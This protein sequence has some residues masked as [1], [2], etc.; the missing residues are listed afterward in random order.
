MVNTAKTV[1]KTRGLLAL[2]VLSFVIP[3]L[4]NAQSDT[5]ARVRGFLSI[6]THRWYILVATVVVIAQGALIAALLTAR[7]RRRATEARSNAILRAIPDLMFLQTRSGVYLD[8][9]TRDP[10]ILLVP[11]EQF[12]G[13]NMRDV[14]PPPLVEMFTERIAQLFNGQEPV[15]AEY[16]I[17]LP[18][19]E[20]GHFEARLVRCEHDK[21]LSI[22]RDVT[23]RSRHEKAIHEEQRRR[24]LANAAGAVGVWDWNLVTGDFYVDAELKALLGY[25][26]K[27]I[28]NHV[29][30]W[31]RLAHPDD[32]ERG[33]DIQSLIQAT[34]GEL[35]QRMIHKD[36][37]MR[38]FLVRGNVTRDERGVPIRLIG[39]SSDITDR[40]RAAQALDQAQA[41]LLR[42]SKLATLG[43]FAGSIT[44]ELAQPLTAI[45]ANSEACLRLLANPNVDPSTL[46][47]SLNDVL[48]SGELARDVISHTRHLF[49]KGD[50]ERS[51]VSLN[52]ILK[53]VS[54]LLSPTLLAK[55][56]VMTIQ[57]APDLPRIRGDRVQLRQVV[58]NLMN[59]AVQA[60]EH[61]GPGR[62]RRLI[63]NAT[64][65]ENG[66]PN[67][68]VQDTGVGLARVDRDRLF[69]AAYTTKPD[70]M[71]WG[72]SISKMIIEAHGG[73]LWA[74]SNEDIGAIF[75]FTL[76]VEKAEPVVNGAIGDALARR[77]NGASPVRR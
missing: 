26:D 63:I 24:T 77:A 73:H 25:E 42:A 21:F 20:V 8:Y 27:E 69:S 41:E 76:P 2:V 72:L 60:M 38:W 67:V 54:I 74:E 36:G 1:A 58:L 16:D 44:H 22:V 32:L 23:E 61:L 12:I 56:I 37:S 64:V 43:E 35:E 57:S 53:D 15:V 4:L 55:N 65:D 70:G 3:A 48:T 59:N 14:L 17:Q 49:S 45:I 68:A 10:S 52:E 29:D 47:E 62:P 75:A 50:L 46:Q 7:A 71:G 33:V 31:R 30:E 18:S 11:P 19:G 51:S 5:S 28:R 66:N 39:T 40:K 9:S 34:T 6:E 13:R